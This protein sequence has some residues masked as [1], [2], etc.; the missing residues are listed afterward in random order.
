MH[1]VIDI[2]LIM[3]KARGA[4]TEGGQA[5]G[6]CPPPHSEG[7]EANILFCPPPTKNVWFASLST[8]KMENMSKNFLRFSVGIK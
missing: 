1:I 2:L 7:G 4:E 3:L 5:G 6:Q 8:Q